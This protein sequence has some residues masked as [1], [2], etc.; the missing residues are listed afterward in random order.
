MGYT[1]MKGELEDRVKA[2]GFKY[3]VVVRPGLIMGARQESRPAEAALRGFAGL[4]KKVSPKLTDS[5]GQDAGDIG[6]AAVAA[7]VQC[8]E[9]KR[10]DGVWEVGQAE[11][12][13]LAGEGAK[14][15]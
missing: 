9:G 4:L 6:R 5:W 11:I 2:L 14:A 3:T 10:E 15:A 13:R 12:V 1:A 8:L 7:G